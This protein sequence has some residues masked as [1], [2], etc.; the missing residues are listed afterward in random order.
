MM[1]ALIVYFTRSGNTETIAH[2]IAKETGADT[3]HLR[4]A[5]S[6]SYDYEEC[7]EEATR[8]YDRHA[9]P[10]LAS[11]PENMDQYTVVFIGYPI[12]MGTMPMAMFTFLEE[13]DFSGKRI[14]PFCTHGGSGLGNS[15]QDIVKLCPEATVLKGIAIDGQHAGSS[16]Y[17]I[18]EWLHRLGV[19]TI[20]HRR[21]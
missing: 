20:S 4:P 12:W 2:T 16:A 6:Y 9:R 13:T 18:E 5:F 11:V 7:V 19:E 14:I 10:L 17:K 15:E 21:V 1:K 3:F 8:E